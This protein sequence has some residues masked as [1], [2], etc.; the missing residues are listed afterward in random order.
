MMIAASVMAPVMARS[1]Q[2]RNPPADWSTLPGVVLKANRAKF[3]FEPVKVRQRCDLNGEIDVQSGANLQ[4]F[5]MIDKK[6]ENRGTKKRVGNP[7]PIEMSCDNAYRL[8]RC[9]R[10][11]MRSRSR[12]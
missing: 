1:V 5:G 10:W 9:H 6:R 8:E 12:A 7:E 11:E 4:E 3:R 2:G